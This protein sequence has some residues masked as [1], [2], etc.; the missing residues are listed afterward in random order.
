MKYSILSII[1][2][3]A[4]SLNIYAQ[5]VRSVDIE[6]TY[7][8][9]ETMAPTVAKRIAL[10]R[11]QLQAIIN[12]FHTTYNQ[13]NFTVIDSKQEDEITFKSYLTSDIS[14]EW[15]ATTKEPTYSIELIDNLQKVTV[16]ISGKVREIPKS[17]AQIDLILCNNTSTPY[18]TT[19]FHNGES[20]FLKCRSSLDGYTMVFIEDEDGNVLRL[21]PFSTNNGSC[22]KIKKG[23]EYT[24]FMDRN[25]AHDLNLI[26][27]ESI[28]ISA[29]HDNELNILSFIYSPT[30]INQPIYDNNASA[31]ETI[32]S[33]RFQKWIS[34]LRAS[35]PE[36]I[37][38]QTPIII[39]L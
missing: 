35:N 1:I 3:I 9:P 32:P 19:T 28:S 16:C 38:K 4:I 13:S 17:R 23:E 11:A 30:L 39:K 10:E 14:G 26:G 21:L 6:Y 22:H 37:V 8:A 34:K 31:F 33:S 27:G 24:F 20:L 29:S 5:D 7:I 36:L 25:D 15:I 18:H 12:E 2:V